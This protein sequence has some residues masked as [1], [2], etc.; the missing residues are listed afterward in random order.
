MPYRSQ[1]ILNRYIE[2]TY[3]YGIFHRIADIKREI[4]R[5]G[6]VGLVHY[7]QAFCHRVMEDVI[8]RDVLDIPIITVEGDLPKRLDARTKLRLEAFI[9][10]LYNR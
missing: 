6:L 7:V 3:P 2:Y 5:R 4:K 9:E 1:N 10:M 8:L